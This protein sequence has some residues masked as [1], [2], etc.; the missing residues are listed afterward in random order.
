MVPPAPARLSM[1]IF[2]PSASL[3]LSDTARATI[4]VEPPGA[5][6][7]TNVIGRSGQDCA[8]A[9]CGDSAHTTM[10]VA[11][12]KSFDADMAH[13][14]K[15]VLLRRFLAQRSGASNI[16]FR[17]TASAAFSPATTDHTVG[18]CL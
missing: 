13:P 9:R 15:N 12:S 10:A 1:M 4:E 5:N 17:R 18:Q 16:P 8:P 7:T 3:I 6:A 2:W 14:P 11:S